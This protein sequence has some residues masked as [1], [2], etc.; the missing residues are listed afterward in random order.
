M[1]DWFRLDGADVILAARIQPRASRDEFVPEAD[2]LRIRITA[3]PVDGTAN[4]HLKRF[5]ARSFG[6]A[7]S[8]VAL[9]RGAAS[10]E[11]TLRISGAAR[12]PADLARYAPT[13]FASKT[14]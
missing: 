7:M 11:K 12:V 2:R 5:L 10:R 13:A 4:E 8:Q 3:P 6:V 1:T 9:L 14:S